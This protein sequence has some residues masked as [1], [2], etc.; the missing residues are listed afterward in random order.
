M[1]GTLSIISCPTCRQFE[2][3]TLKY[4]LYGVRDGTVEP[5]TSQL[6]NDDKSI[7]RKRV[8][9]QLKHTMTTMTYRQTQLQFYQQLHIVAKS[10]SYEL[11]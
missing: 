4:R 8:N 10:Y 7:Y 5:K 6:E 11:Q 2:F 9:Q 1:Q 3:Y